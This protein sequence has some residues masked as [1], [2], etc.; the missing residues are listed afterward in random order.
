MLVSMTNLKTW[1]TVTSVISKVIRH[2]TVGLEPSGHQDFK[3]TTII[4][5]SMVIE[6]LSEDQNLCR[7][8]TNHQRLKAMDT[9]TIGTTILGTVVTIV[10][11]METFLELMYVIALYISPIHFP[12]LSWMKCDQLTSWVK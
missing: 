11:S 5:R 6:L 7:H 2:M 1:V 10:K 8:L 9:T 4:A 12:S 3:F